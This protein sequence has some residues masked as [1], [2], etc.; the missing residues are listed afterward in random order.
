MQDYAPKA[1]NLY[2]PSNSGIKKAIKKGLFKINNETAKTGSWVVSGQTIDLIENETN[3]PKVYEFNLP[4]VFEDESIA[5]INKPAGITVSGNQ[6]KTIYNALPFNLTKSTEI[7]ALSWP[8]PVHRLD[9]QTSGILVIA[10]TKT[11]QIELDKQF[12]NKTIQKTY[13]TLVIGEVTQNEDISTPIEGKLSTTKF[14]INEVT[15]SLKFGKLSFLKVYPKTG[16][17]HQIRIHMASIGHPILGDKLYGTAEALHKGK[18]LFLNAT[19]IE[20]F[21][22]KTQKKVHYK[23]DVPNKFITLINR[24]IDRFINA[25]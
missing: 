3:K 23:I 12:K 11:A 7:D 24:E 2:I 16:R 22:P 20:F 10:K 17:T 8:T 13:S 25:N 4:I 19:E 15:N 18:G 5:I 9:N 21:H 14:E 6:F 1:F